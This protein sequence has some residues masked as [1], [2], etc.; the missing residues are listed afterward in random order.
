MR[1]V[2]VG[3]TGN[4]GTSLLTALEHEPTVDSIVGVAR[5]LPELDV[6]KTEWI[7]ADIVTDDLVSIFT[8]ADVVVHLAWAIQPSHDREVTWRINQAGSNKV[9][10][11]VAEAKVPAL[12]YA[13]SIGAYSPGPKDYGVDESWPTRGIAT[14]FYSVDKAAVERMLDSFEED[15]P[16]VRVVRLRP[17]LI[18]KREAGAEVRRLFAGPLFPNWGLHPGLIPFVPNIPTL[19]FQC[20]HSYDIGEAYRLAITTDARG[21]FN[22]AASPV[23]D[24]PKLAELLG[25]RLVPAPPRLIRTFAD[26]TWR[27]HLQPTPAGWVDMALQTPLMD[28]KRA[29]EDLG[30]EPRYS[31]EDALTEELDGLRTN[32]GMDTPP[33]EPGA[34]GPLRIK[35]F[36][37]GIGRFSGVKKEDAR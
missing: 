20:V 3:A 18:F 5:R 30:W 29:T 22:V 7:A 26:V 21:A 27:L 33:L 9:F 15:N 14:S 19:R 10:Q 4:A 23:I 36:L 37:T 1:V 24:P 28:T 11:A 6:P 34:G 8:G 17:G 16:D 12:V 35:E 32:S 25:A 2:I 31:A 13:S